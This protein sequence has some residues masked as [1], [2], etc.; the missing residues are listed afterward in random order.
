MAWP[1]LRMRQTEKAAKGMS[2]VL[3]SCM[4]AT[5]FVQAS[6]RVNPRRISSMSRLA[7][8]TAATRALT[9]VPMPSASTAVVASSVRS[10]TD[11]VTADRAGPLRLLG[12]DG[13]YIFPGVIGAFFISL[14]QGHQ[15]SHE[16]LAFGRA[17]T[18]ELRHVDRHLHLVLEKLVGLFHGLRPQLF[19]LLLLLLLVCDVHEDADDLLLLLQACT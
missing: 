10:T 17:F 3:A 14:A 9:P 13:L 5:T 7:Y 8:M 1:L 6:L 19:Q 15:L 16:G 12:H 4:V 11:E 18:E 2:E